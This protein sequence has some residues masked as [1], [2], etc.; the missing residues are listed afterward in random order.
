V[1]GIL[2]TQVHADASD[3][4]EGMTKKEVY[5]QILEQARILFDGQRN[6]VCYELQNTGI[7]LHHKGHVANKDAGLVRSIR[8]CI[9]TNANNAYCTCKLRH[10]L[11]I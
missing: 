3:F 1:S 11:I 8:L 5:A 9:Q 2:N 7:L 6:W 10:T 4:A